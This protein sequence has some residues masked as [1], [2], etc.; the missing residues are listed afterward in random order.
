GFL[1]PSTAQAWADCPRGLVNDPYPGRCSR[2]TDTNDDGIC[3][4]SQPKPSDPTTTT[5]V[6]SVTSTAATDPP[7]GDC[8]L[9]PCV[10]CGACFSLGASI[11]SANVD[12]A[13]QDG[14]ADTGADAVVL[15]ASSTP[16]S[17]TSTISTTT[18][19]SVGTLQDGSSSTKASSSSLFT[20]YNVSPIAV[21]FFLIYAVSFVLYKTKRIK[22]STHRK[23]WNVLLLATFL[24]TGIFGLILAIQIDY[25]L[26]FTLP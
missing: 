19:P 6:P 12:N 3:D 14:L 17:S 21:G 24:V 20:R 9:G 18:H 23:I 5:T 22:V 25:K 10:G 4:L 7:S 8:P 1:S 13:S 2:Y 26:P 15:A 11:S 16:A